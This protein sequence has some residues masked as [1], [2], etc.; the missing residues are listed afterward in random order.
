MRIRTLLTTAAV[1]AALVAGGVAGPASAAD[2]HTPVATSI[3]VSTTGVIVPALTASAPITVNF[4]TYQYAAGNAFIQTPAGV[5]DGGPVSRDAAGNATVDLMEL[6][7]RKAYDYGQVPA[8]TYGVYFT[9]EAKS[10]YVNYTNGNSNYADYAAAQS[11]VVGV[12]VTKLTTSITGW[13]TKSKSAKYGKKIRV[14][15]PTFHNVGPDATV[16]IQYK[17]KGAKK[18]KT[19]EKSVTSSY[20]PADQKIKTQPFNSVHVKGKLKK[21]KKGTYYLRLVIKESAF[22]SGSTSKPIKLTWH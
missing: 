11:P 9:S 14:S 22:V 4:A 5:I 19:D 15:S 17:K 16:I 7:S 6:L 3:A 8:G 12:T 18:W 2:V 1:S 21:L 10:T 20:A 13:K